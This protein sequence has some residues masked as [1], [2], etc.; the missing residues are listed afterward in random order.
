VEF[1]FAK[2][3]AVR[4]RRTTRI[5]ELEQSLLKLV[6]PQIDRLV[7]DSIVVLYHK[8]PPSKKYV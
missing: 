1:C 7:P 2:L 4:L 8:Q 6:D 3:Q 5:G